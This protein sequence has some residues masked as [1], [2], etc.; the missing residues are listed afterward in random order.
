WVVVHVD[1]S[2][3][4][5]RLESTGLGAGLLRALGAK[6]GS[7]V[8]LHRGVALHHGGWDLLEIGDGAALGR[9]VSLGLVTYDRQQLV[10]APVSIGPRATLD[11]RARMA[12]G[13][14]MEAGAVPGSAAAL[15]QDTGVPACE[16]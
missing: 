8:H 11:T 3:P 10:F 9:D 16:R 14:R 4:W 13:S 15:P 1:R 2:L 5:D 12:A 6:I 7:D